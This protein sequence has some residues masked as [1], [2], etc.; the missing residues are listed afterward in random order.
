MAG[1]Q[2]LLQHPRAWEGPMVTMTQ[3]DPTQGLLAAIFDATRVAV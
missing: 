3:R 2:K 1:A